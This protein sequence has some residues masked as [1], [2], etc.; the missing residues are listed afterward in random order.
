MG[1]MDQT[2]LHAAALIIPLVIAI[3]FH[4]VS[5]G[6][7][8]GMLGDPTAAEQRRLSLNPLRHVD[9]MGTVILPGFLA[10][11]SLPVFGWAKPVPVNHRRLRNPRRDMMLVAAAGPGSNLVMAAI[12]S[13]LFG[14]LM[15]PY[16]NGAE[17]GAVMAFVAQ[18]L[19]NFVLINIFLA[20]FNL[21]PIPPFDGSHIVEGLLPRSAARVYAKVRPFGFPLVFLV[22][23][24]LPWLF[25]QWDIVGWLV[26]PPVEW[27]AS[28]FNVIA[29]VFAGN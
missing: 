5:H 29:E 18:N 25:P 17:P 23:L 12:A 7:V 26:I 22:L 19:N 27:L 16:V 28:Q 10:L 4:E 2:L 15:R 20:F 24:V 14:V 11:A 3:V 21:L 1:R 8:A 13:A 6:W 9:P